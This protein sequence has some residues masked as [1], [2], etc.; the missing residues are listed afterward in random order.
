M[1]FD[2]YTSGYAGLVVTN[3]VVPLGVSAVPVSL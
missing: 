2:T 3:I 1:G